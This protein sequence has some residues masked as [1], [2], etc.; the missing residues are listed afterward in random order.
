[1]TRMGGSL[2]RWR[3]TAE[4]SPDR[5]GKLATARGGLAEVAV[6]ARGLRPVFWKELL[7]SRRETT[8]A[9]TRSRAESSDNP[10]NLQ[11]QTHSSVTITQLCCE[12]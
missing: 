5:A 10:Q 9:W 12:C 1:M 8:K 4:N 3:L 6:G 7:L 2:H 11:D